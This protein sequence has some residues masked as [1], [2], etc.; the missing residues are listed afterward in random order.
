MG[1]P[2]CKHASFRRDRYS[3]SAGAQAAVCLEVDGVEPQLV[4]HVDELLGV[5][6]E[7]GG[8]VE[9]YE[10]VAGQLDHGVAPVRES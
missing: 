5:H 8:P 4:G 10:G 2:R 6:R 1:R 7:A 3:R 9:G